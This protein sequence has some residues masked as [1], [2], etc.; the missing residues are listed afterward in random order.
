MEQLIQL[1]NLVSERVAGKTIQA[2][3]HNAYLAL[4]QRIGAIFDQDLDK[5][6]DARLQIPG[7]KQIL[8]KKQVGALFSISSVHVSIF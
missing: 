2:K 4:Q 6:V 7:I 3:M 8:E 5:S 1:Q